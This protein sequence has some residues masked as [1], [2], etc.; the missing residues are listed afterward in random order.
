MVTEGRSVLVLR[1]VGERGGGRAGWEV[2]LTKD[3]KKVPR[4][5]DLFVKLIVVVVSL[6]YTHNI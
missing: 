2:R 5:I 6:V 1:W 4:L 3:D